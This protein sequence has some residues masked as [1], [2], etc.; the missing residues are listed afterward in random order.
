[1]YELIHAV[2]FLTRRVSLSLLSLAG[3]KSWDGAPEA[4]LSLCRLSSST[5]CIIVINPTLAGRAL[6]RP[7]ATKLPPLG[8]AGSA[9]S[10]SCRS[11]LD[12]VVADAAALIFAAAGTLSPAVTGVALDV[13]AAGVRVVPAAGDAAAVEPASCLDVCFAVSSSTPLELLPPPKKAGRG[14]PSSASPPTP[15][16]SSWPNATRNGLN[17]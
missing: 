11:V 15:S 16:S 12:V 2:F 6:T 9:V 13:G 4:P 14:S 17:T 3:R 8:R 10:S 1:M 7:P 5:S